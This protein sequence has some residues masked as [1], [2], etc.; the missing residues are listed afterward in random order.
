MGRGCG[1]AYCWR[2]DASRWKVDHDPAL[3]KA[4]PGRIETASFAG[5]P[6]PLDRTAWRPDLAAG[7]PAKSGTP[8]RAQTLF[9]ASNRSRINDAANPP[10]PALTNAGLDRVGAG[11]VGGGW[12]KP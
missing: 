8:N 4:Q 6:G 9:A 3:R 11:G 5:L 2:E 10:S 7:V 1:G 12:V